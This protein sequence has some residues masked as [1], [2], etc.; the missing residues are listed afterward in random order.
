MPTPA[1]TDAAAGSDV[2]VWGEKDTSK[3]YPPGTKV[4]VN[5]EEVDISSI[6]DFIG[7][8]A[9]GQRPD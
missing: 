9:K 3:N 4:T 2:S 8:K 6:P 7:G 1:E 5:G